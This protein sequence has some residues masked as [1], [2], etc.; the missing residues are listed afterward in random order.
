MEQASIK[1]TV[2][3]RRRPTPPPPHCAAPQ[4]GGTAKARLTGRF[5]TKRARRYSMHNEEVE[6]RGGSQVV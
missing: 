6:L 2:K 4:R 1:A 5:R 3:V